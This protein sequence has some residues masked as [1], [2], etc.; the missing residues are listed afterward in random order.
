MIICLIDYA[1]LTEEQKA[2]VICLYKVSEEKIEDFTIAID[3]V[4][5]EGDYLS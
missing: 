5:D 3:K 2:K 4:H 1:D